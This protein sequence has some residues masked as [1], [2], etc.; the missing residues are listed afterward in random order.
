MK[1]RTFCALL[2]WFPVFF[3]FFFWFFLCTLYLFGSRP[4]QCVL[5]CVWTGSKI[6]LPND[7]RSVW[8]IP[9]KELSKNKSYFFCF[10]SVFRRV[11]IFEWWL[12]F[13]VYSFMLSHKLSR[14]TLISSIKWHTVNMIYFHLNVCARIC[15]FFWI[16]KHWFWLKSRERSM[17]V[18]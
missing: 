1:W 9:V 17:T 15:F 11:Q 8:S 3:S 12:I 14:R 4:T 10:F 5:S 18:N 13:I 16:F 7:W 2:F 6:S